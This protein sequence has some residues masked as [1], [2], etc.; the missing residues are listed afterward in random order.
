MIQALG[1][2]D[3]LARCVAPTAPPELRRSVADGAI[4]MAP[5][6]RLCTLAALL[7]DPLEEIR[8]AA[9]EAWKNLPAIFVQDA[10]ANPRLPE[11]VLDFVAA[12][13]A[14]DRSL[15]ARVLG[16]P[17]VG[18]RTLERFVES[19]D[20]ELL[21]AIALNQRVLDTHTEVAVR[22]LQNPHLPPDERGRLQSL[23]APASPEGE[24]EPD[25]SHLPQVLL[26]EEEDNATPAVQ[27][28]FEAGRDSQNLYQIIQSLT[29]AE[30]I[31]L[32]TLG[33][34]SARRLLIRDTNKVVA[35][36]VIRSPKIREDEVLVAVQDRTVADEIIRVVLGRKD[37]MKSYPIRLA[38]C[39]N[40]KTPIP[41]ALRLL[42]TLQ[43]RDLRQISK[44]RNVPSAVSSGA[45]RVLAR[46]GK[47]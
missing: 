16:H 30:K 45:I 37:W 18:R 25:I 38:L 40:P 13:D 39:Q 32:A 5:V 4:P 19:E 27:E 43:G 47:T 36:A 1:L 15:V 23:Y 29:V 2:P 24:E 33:S 11:L 22:L 21:C 44:S 34:K 26:E 9:R 35:G 28:L 17:R 3:S 7:A 46:R 42:E 8:I 31:K 12:L 14:D 20:E 6:E 10:V 41:R